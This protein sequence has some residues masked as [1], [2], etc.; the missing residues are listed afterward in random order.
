MIEERKNIFK[1]R[2]VFLVFTVFIL[3]SYVIV[4]KLF[5]LQETNKIALQ[6]A[7]KKSLERENFLKNFIAHSSDILTSINNSE[8][9]NNY[10]EDKVGKKELINLFEVIANNHSSFMQLRYIDE[11][12][13][14]IVRIDRL[15][16]G[17]KSFVITDDKLQNKAN[18]YY[19]SDSKN[20]SFGKV[21]F[22][23]IDL[24]IENKKVEIPY[25]PTLRAIL[26]I[27]K[28]NQFG[29]ILIINYFMK[30]FLEKFVD[31]PLYD[32][33]LLNGDGYP[34]I[35]FD[36]NKNWGFYNK[37][38]YNIS[39]E[40]KTKYQNIISQKVFQTDSFVS[41]QFDTQIADG[42]IMIL[43]LKK[44]YLQREVDKHNL[45]Y[46][47]VFIIVLVVAFVAIYFVAKI[48]QKLVH[49]LSLSEKLNKKLKELNTQL[50]TIL[51]TSK[52]G[53]ALVD[54]DMKFLFFNKSYC[55]MTKYTYE[56]LQTKSCFS[57]TQK[58]DVSKVESMLK[59]LLK[60]GYINNF[61]KRCI[62]KNGEEFIVL[63][64][65][66]LMPDKQR[67]LIITKD[68]TQ[69]KKQELKLK[70]QDEIL[71]QQSKMAAMGE[72]LENIAHQW[73]QPLSVITTSATGLKVQK[74]YQL[75]TDDMLNQGLE[76]IV[77]YAEYL[78]NT[79]EDFRSF[80][81]KDKKKQYFKIYEVIDKTLFLVASKFKNR[82]IEVVIEKTDLEISGYK[83][84]FL[85]VI[86]NILNNARDALENLPLDTR[87]IILIDILHINNKAIITISDNAGGIPEDIIDKVFEQHFTTK[88]DDNGTGIGLYMS[89]EIIE[90]HME[91]QLEVE[92]KDLEY[93]GQKSTGASFSII[94]PLE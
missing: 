62:N 18:R 83:N 81:K 27:D 47:V 48:V 57:M 59:K 1:I 75:L 88:E 78:S 54:I 69:L 23:A 84:E 13:K 14:E 3:L 79:I 93:K 4:D 70:T 51:N 24:N 91:G 15:H 35:H 43:Q 71:I 92:N 60:K 29:G 34:L 16:Q 55:E 58:E 41:R 28:N 19:F 89:K 74:E 49:K 90:K 10:L 65:L 42:L 26:P 2:L 38:K 30:D 20:K 80:F 9:F 44:E 53:I 72:M 87:R 64:S 63:S 39:N 67:I 25:K 40:Y 82:N 94:L 31:M 12:G 11:T 50:N 37:N 77:S 46:L 45:Q 68:I 36:K 6:N 56:E 52:D 5:F 85:Q 22:S 61:E 76:S 17:D 32:T 7:L 66:V 33:I 8:F 73:R 86:M 21:W